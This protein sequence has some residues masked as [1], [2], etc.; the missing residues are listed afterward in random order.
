MLGLPVLT[1]VTVW[2]QSINQS[3]NV[4]VTQVHKENLPQREAC[5]MLFF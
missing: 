4:C 3:I 5:Y 1:V 2:L